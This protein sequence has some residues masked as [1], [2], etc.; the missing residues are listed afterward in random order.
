VTTQPTTTTP[1]YDIDIN[2]YLLDYKWTRKH[3]VVSFLHTNPD[4]FHG[5]LTS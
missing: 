1:F 2:T 5:N 3:S 4:I